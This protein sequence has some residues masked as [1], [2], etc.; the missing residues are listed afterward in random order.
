[1]EQRKVA[2]VT[3]ATSGIGQWIA[4]GLA[5]AG[6][7]VV[8]VARDAGRAEAT[9]RW[10]AS[11]VR[12]AGTEAVLADLSSLAQARAAGERISAA[13]PRVAVLV[14]NA[15]LF[16][17]RRRVTPEGRELVLAVNH[18]APF[19]LTRALEGALRDGAPSRVVNV[20]STASDRASMDLDDLEGA[21]RW[22]ML[23]AYGRSKLALMMASFEWARRLDGSGIAVNVVHPG[24]VGTR[25][26]AMPGIAGLVW[27][28][29]TPFMLR[30]E[31]GADTPLHVAL[32][33]ELERVTGRYFKR[34][35]EARPNRQALDRA[36]VERLWAETERL[37]AAA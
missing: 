32:A 23:R 28:A 29:A 11:Q 20:G 25:I 16:S 17:E 37:V 34:R 19:A 15:G 7:H 8:L 35:Q 26:G 36:L 3:G 1:M 6:M 10:I 13:H 21:R 14:N 30:P 12:D 24:L 4:L 27:R 31:Q 33:P 5:R 22:N 9:R 2:V 18:L